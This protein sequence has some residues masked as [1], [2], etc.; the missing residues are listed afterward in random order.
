[1]DFSGVWCS[2]RDMASE[3][4]FSVFLQQKEQRANII[5]CGVTHGIM[6]LTR[7]L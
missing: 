7:G 2:G 5:Y 1:M 3:L 4:H 6:E